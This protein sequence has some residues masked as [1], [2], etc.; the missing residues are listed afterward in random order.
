MTGRRVSVVVPSVP[1][2]GPVSNDAYFYRRVALNLRNGY[3]V[4][5]SNV[6]ESVAELLTRVADELDRPDVDDMGVPEPCRFDRCLLDE[7]HYPDV[8]HRFYAYVSDDPWAPATPQPK[9]R[10]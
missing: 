8:P 10:T 9:V 6:T 4:G 1:F 3:P 5:G 7:G 2:P